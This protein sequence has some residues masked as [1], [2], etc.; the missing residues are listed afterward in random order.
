MHKPIGMKIAIPQWQ[1][2]VSPVF[3]V[4][5]NLLLIDVEDGRETR[6]EEKRFLVTAPSARV[7]EFST[8]GAGVLICGAIST[9]LET[10]LIAAGVQVSIH[11]PHAG[12]DG[13]TVTALISAFYPGNCADSVKSGSSKRAKN[14]HRRSISVESM[15]WRNREPVGDGLCT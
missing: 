7:T 13:S 10:S 1:E 5:G 9:A 8:F 15:R 4:A 3:D 14:G 6:R 2:R 11:A 12:R